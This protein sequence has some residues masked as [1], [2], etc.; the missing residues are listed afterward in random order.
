MRC[1]RARELIDAYADGE[2]GGDDRASVASHLE[3]CATCGPLLRDIAHTSSVL[4]QLGRQPAP[5]DLAARVRRRLATAA[6]ER[7]KTWR[8]FVLP[9]AGIWRQAA[10]LA[11]CCAVS[12]FLT[13]SVVTST[14]QADRLQQ[15]LLAAH[16]RSLLQDSPIQVASSNS[17]TVKPWFAGKVDVAPEVKD[18]T[19]QGFP[20]LGGRLDYVHQQRVGA[21]VYKRRMHVISVFVWRAPGSED[22]PPS[23]AS[24]S[25]YN[26]LRWTRGGVTYWAVSDLDGA[27]L[28]RLQGLL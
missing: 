5:A 28:K 17:H 9:A 25:G 20:L 10:A 3:T 19:A 23:S 16:M 8:S 7:Q 1:D 21:L 22:L 27:E 2:L 13:W 18:L 6:G 12:V 26:L 14:A 4:T 24:S 11:A 15:E